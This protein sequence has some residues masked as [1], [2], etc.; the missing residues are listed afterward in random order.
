ML[1][2]ECSILSCGSHWLCWNWI[3]PAGAQL[4]RIYREQWCPEK[5]GLH[6]GDGSFLWEWWLTCLYFFIFSDFRPCPRHSL[7]NIM[8]CLTWENIWM[9]VSSFL[10]KYRH[11]IQFTGQNTDFSGREWVWQPVQGE[12][13][14]HYFLSHDLNIGLNLNTC[15]TNLSA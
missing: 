8:K 12:M 13:L 11:S 5:W 14:K 2:N 3:L 9:H 4:F 1:G 7:E 10:R 15:L 6:S